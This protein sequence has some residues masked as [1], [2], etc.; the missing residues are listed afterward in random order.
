[1]GKSKKIKSK[2]KSKR[3]KIKGE[4]QIPKGKRQNFKKKANSISC[5]PLPIPNGIGQGLEVRVK[6]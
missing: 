3:E 2:Y 1:L 5:S 4:N 6:K